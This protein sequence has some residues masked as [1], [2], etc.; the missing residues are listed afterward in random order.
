MVIASLSITSCNGDEKVENTTEVS[1]KENE[2]EEKL[3]VGIQARTIK[4]FKLSLLIFKQ[5]LSM[6]QSQLL[7]LRS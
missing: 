6:T 3:I 1:E 7:K 4:P 5:Q 2:K